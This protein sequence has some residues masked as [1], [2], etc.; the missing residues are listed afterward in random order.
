[1]TGLPQLL[2]CT[3]VGVVSFM[4]MERR[5]LVLALD[6]LNLGTAMV[7]PRHSFGIGT[8]IAC[9][10]YTKI[11]NLSRQISRQLITIYHSCNL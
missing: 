2:Q 7:E 9:L 10:N 11:E 5:L 3:I 4:L 6:V 1:M 8:T